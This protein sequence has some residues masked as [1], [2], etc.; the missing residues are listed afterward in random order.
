MALTNGVHY[1]EVQLSITLS[2][3]SIGLSTNITHRGYVTLLTLRSNH[4]RCY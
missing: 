1:E 3:R 4:Q 2:M